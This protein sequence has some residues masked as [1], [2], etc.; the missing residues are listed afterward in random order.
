V[1][2]TLLPYAGVNVA[3]TPSFTV[4]STR[5]SPV[6]INPSVPRLNELKSQAFYLLI[7]GICRGRSYAGIIRGTATLD[8][9]TVT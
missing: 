2:I 3:V 7:Y 1:A 9:L 8:L 4:G 5:R 6:S